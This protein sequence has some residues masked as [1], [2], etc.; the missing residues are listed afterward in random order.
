[1]YGNG[2][3]S[4]LSSVSTMATI[5]STLFKM[6]GLWYGGMVN[7]SANWWWT[8]V[9]E[10]DVRRRPGAWDVSMHDAVSNI[11]ASMRSPA[12]AAAP[13]PYADPR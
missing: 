13:R 6:L 9:G 3:E 2:G 8:S 1:M 11:D 4:V 5:T 7:D 10:H 12:A